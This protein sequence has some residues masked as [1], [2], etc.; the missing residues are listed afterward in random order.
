MS[1]PQKAGSNKPSLG[2]IKK[3]IKEVAKAYKV[4]PYE[5]NKTQFWEYVAKA[6][7]D[8]K[9]W[10][11]RNLGGLAAIRD[12]AFPSPVEEQKPENPLAT[13]T[14]EKL[15]GHELSQYIADVIKE[16][17]EKI[18]VAPHE[19]T[20]YEFSRYI[21]LHFGENDAGVARYTIT[22]AGGFNQVRDA[23][24]PIFPSDNIVDRERLHEHVNLNR[25]LGKMYASQQFFQESLEQYAARVFSGKV[26]ALPAHK[27][28]KTVS[29]VVNVVMSDLH[30]GS[31]I[32]ETETGYQRFGKLEEARRLSALTKQVCSYKEQYRDSTKLVVHLIGDIIQG[33]LHDPRDG[34]VQAE[35]FA[36]ALHL[37]SQVFAHFS[38]AFPEVDIYCATGN[39]GRNMARHPER[40]IH[41]KWDSI[42]TQLYVA[43]SFA[44]N[45]LKNVRFHI[46]KSP[47]VKVPVLEHKIF[48]THG[49]TVLKPGNPGSAIKIKDLADQINAIN[50]SLN[51]ADE[52]SIFAVGHVHVPSITMLN[53]GVIMLTNGCLVPVDPF[54]VSIGILESHCGQWIWESVKGHA[55]GDIR[56]IRVGKQHDVDESL[57]AIIVPWKGLPI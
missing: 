5:V 1:A 40:A 41:E 39:H 15:S 32:S 44:C 8:V 26:Q 49:D 30:I 17:A 19:L 25:R 55:M 56:L 47:Y 4:K 2:L 24:F 12:Q 22:R 53:N 13:A 16:C 14:A 48:S 3:T 52:Y 36:R 27:G 42:E 46:P 20:W 18:G 6:N 23:Y 21:K 57:D 37:L 33:Q 43:L 35:Q 10:A 51:D 54:S 11:V 50:A 34:A 9:E 38:T 28:S 45:A 31:D 7:I 29:R